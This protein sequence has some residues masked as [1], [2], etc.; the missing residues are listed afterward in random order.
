MNK[1]SIITKGTTGL[2]VA[3]IGMAGRFPCAKDISQ[4]WDNLLNEV[5]GV[6]KLTDEELMDMGI[7]KDVFDHENYV[8]ARGI[9]P[10]IEYFD[11]EF[12]HYTPADANYMDPQMR[13]MHEEVYHAIEDA[14]Y[15]SDDREE[16]IGLFLGATNN[17]SWEASSLKRCLD[18]RKQS[19]AATQLNDKDFIATRIAYALNLKGPAITMHCACSTSLATIDTAYR[20]ILTG[21]C[22]IAVAGGSGLTLPYK[23]GYTYQEGMI[24]SKDGKCKAFD[25]DANGTV[26]GNGVAV[27]VLKSLKKALKD[28]DH[29]YAVI[30]GSAMNND[31]E[32]KVGFTAPSIEGQAEVIKKALSMANVTPDTIS[33]IETH[34]TGTKLGDPIEVQALAKVFRSTGKKSC[35]IGS[36]KASVG[37]MDVASG[38]ASFIKTVKI[39]ENKII[40]RSLNF[41]ELNPNINIDNTMLYIADK[42]IPCKKVGDMPL[43]AG[44]SAF[45]IGGTNV[46]VIL[47]QAPDKEESSASQKNNVLCISANSEDAF[48]KIVNNLVEYIKE[49]PGVN[50]TDLAW[51]MQNRQRRLKYRHTFVYKDIPDL[52]EKLNDFIS[53]DKNLKVVGNKEKKNIFFLFS[54]QGAQYP[55]MALEL[56]QAEEMFQREM[57]KCFAILD[58]LG[59]SNIKEI[60]FGNVSNFETYLENTEITQI[61]L[62]IVEYSMAKMLLYWG[63]KPQGMIGHSIGEIVAACI[64]EVFSLEDGI[65]LVLKRGSLMEKTSVGAMAAVRT[66]EETLNGLLTD[67]LFVAAVNSPNKYTVSGAVEDIEQFER[68]CKEKN[69]SITRLHVKH[70]FHSHYMNEVL[71]E[72]E[73]FCSNIQYKDAKIPYI[74][75]VTGDW[76]KKEQYANPNYYCEHITSCVQYEK[77]VQQLL[78]KGHPL[79]IEVGPGKSLC[80][81]VREITKKSDVVTINM[82]RHCLEEIEDSY[83]LQVAL[84]R[85][86]EQGI[87]VN[88]KKCYEGQRRN[89]IPL[90]LYP[91]DKKKCSIHVDE[92][93]KMFYPS[94]EVVQNRVYVEKQDYSTTIEHSQKRFF[95]ID[96]N[97]SLIPFTEKNEVK[98]IAIIFTK[99]KEEIK[100]TMEFML[101][102]TKIIVTYGSEYV[103]NGMSGAIIRENNESDI[104]QL[105]SDLK[106][107][108]YLG[109]IVLYHNSNTEVLENEID[110]ICKSVQEHAKGIISD[111]VILDYFNLC[112]NKK[113]I[114]PFCV[115]KNYLYKEFKVRLIS[116]K[117]DF[118]T[119]QGRKLWCQ[120]MR[121][122]LESNEFNSIIVSYRDKQ[123]YTPTLI[124]VSEENKLESKLMNNE[125]FYIFCSIEE[126][127]MLLNN[128]DCLKNQGNVYIQPY[129]KRKSGSNVPVNKANGSENIHIMDAIFAENATMFRDEIMKKAMDIPAYKT[130]VIIDTLYLEKN[131]IDLYDES[132]KDI[133][134]ELNKMLIG[135]NVYSCMLSVFG[136]KAPEKWNENGTKWIRKNYI[137]DLEC[138]S[139][140]IYAE[141]IT[142][143]MNTNLKKIIRQMYMTQLHTIYYEYDI[144][145][146][147]ISCKGFHDKVQEGDK[148]VEEAREIITKVLKDLLG[149]DEIDPD[150]DLFELGMDSVKNIDFMNQLER[151]GYK[152]LANNIYNSKTIS[153][154]TELVAYGK[155]QEDIPLIS[156]DSIIHMLNR[157]LQVDCTMYRD[158]DDFVL[159]FVKNLDESKKKDIISYLIKS[160]IQQSLIPQYIFNQEYEKQFKE[161][162]ELHI[163]LKSQSNNKSSI[164]DVT[165]YLDRIDDMQEELKQAISSQPIECKY[166]ISP[167]QKRHFCGE[168]RL[169]LYLIHFDELIDISL[170]ERAFSDIVGS[171]GLLRSFL[172]RSFGKFRW[173]EFQIPKALKLPQIDLSNYTSE[174]Q[175][176]I[177][178]YI[179][180]KE[181]SMDFK[182]VD[183]PMYR[184]VLIKYNEK[185]YDLLLQFDHSIFDV[186]SGQIFRTGIISRYHALVR[187]TSKAM[188]SSKGYRHL[189]KQIYKGPVNITQDEIIQKFE[190]RE[191]VET[192]NNLIKKLDTNTNRRVKSLQYSVDLEQFG[193]NVDTFS[194]LTYLYARVISR[195]MK[196]DKI[197]FDLLD[198][199]RVYEDKEYMDVM[200]MVLSG[201]PFYVDLSKYNRKTLHKKIQEKLEIVNKNNVSL[202]NLVHDVPSFIKNFKVINVV[203]SVNNK[204]FYTPFLLNFVGN[205]ES[206]YDKIWELTL[207][208]LDDENQE[209]L[210]YGE[211]YFISKS[212]NTELQILVLCKCFDNIND[213][214]KILDEELEI[215][216]ENEKVIEMK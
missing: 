215:M 27:V 75:N 126:M 32:R 89:R 21:A 106:A 145:T 96:W 65:K 168:V 108:S 69:I 213:L 47:E 90:P 77:G 107:A 36:L 206:E 154:L 180:E 101:H 197:A 199:T 84:G 216:I 137:E 5:E 142:Q 188:H 169:Q 113:D 31:G 70:A 181:W 207:N 6:T 87:K 103:F 128:R 57:D 50:A 176:E 3:V 191:Y 4:L 88:W 134:M 140:R 76:I 19:S 198:K 214:K 147:S 166:N 80:T 35:G 8:K 63:L 67:K 10:D 173:K 131:Q 20:N 148:K 151:Y 201:L 186:T 196:T 195:I 52:Q 100:E 79:F 94:E 56:Y 144:L 165:K 24:Y 58:D 203:R 194:L 45:G 41:N 62:F 212:S 149:Y 92:F 17:F 205:V 74:S 12:F 25:K 202:L 138:K 143:L 99:N 95:K 204:S 43:R 38:A 2:E 211:C 200:G 162:K 122:E 78:K 9:F 156:F 133:L 91:F 171:H 167:I 192:Y 55:K 161:K 72:F 23:S 112:E 104:Q 93:Q 13:A 127:E 14:G 179:G 83:Q 81:F 18:E 116:C 34:G 68:V 139:Y 66:D 187:G 7:T 136:N 158:K 102:W 164:E 125:A 46:H 117:E 157:D 190:L 159:M 183:K 123:R 118:S 82:F 29:I 86:W 40:P 184:V 141:N 28:G 97:S 111:V 189:L 98:K 60:F 150:T 170:L 73:Q 152:I 177:M 146:S 175:E 11:P 22:Q 130:V 163:L 120:C 109:D 115:D 129:A 193:E 71:E 53:Q 182:T 210:D 209:K 51:T 114:I 61:L 42:Q 54:G 160:D 153:K 121:Q 59:K 85:I 155:I 30:K 124:S 26:E 105:F 39:L 1:K 44:V 172:Y 132:T 64:A 33:Y 185:K 110:S 174:E 16:T 178:K 15:S 119:E 208:Q 49:N 135:K 37:H 48:K